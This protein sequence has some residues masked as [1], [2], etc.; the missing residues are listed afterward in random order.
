MKIHSTAV[1]EPGARLGENIT[2]GPFAYVASDTD[3]GRGCHLGP[4]STV[5]AYTTL[6]EECQVHAG[7]VVGDLPQDLAFN[8]GDVSF[9]KVGHRCVLREGV[10]IHRG[11]KPGSTT[12]VGDDCFLMANSHVGHNAIL[13]NR[14]IMANGAL[15]GGY[16]TIGDRAFISGNCMIHQF[17]R[18]GR[19][20]MMSGGSA[21]QKDIPPFCMT[22]SSATSILLGLNVVGLRR[23][24]FD[25]EE[26]QQ[27]KEAFKRLFCSGLLVS[28][29]IEQLEASG[30]SASVLELC[31]FIKTSKRGVSK[32]FKA[33]TR[34]PHR[35]LG[36]SNGSEPQTPV[37]HGDPNLRGC[38][39][40]QRASQ[41]TPGE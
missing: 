7:A 22:Q 15:V 8:R 39:K 20:A 11:T 41:I 5:L 27:L 40:S 13:G 38:L 30:P 24:G 35:D 31:N 16:A 6:G 12:R 9:V 37:R 29:A 23:A 1:V 21:A 10:T 17:A 4:R 14:V 2:I 19:L 34:H 36:L 32:A 28:T 26:R 18:V 3:I 25:S 33:K